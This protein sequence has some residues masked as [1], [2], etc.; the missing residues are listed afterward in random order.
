MSEPWC[1]A[2]DRAIAA[3]ALAVLADPRSPPEHR[4]EARETLLRPRLDLTK[5]STGDLH[6]MRRG[7]A[8]GQ[9]ADPRVFP[10]GPLCCSC[11]APATVVAPAQPIAAVVA[12]RAAQRASEPA[13]E[14]ASEPAAELAYEVASEP[15][16][17]AAGPIAELAKLGGTVKRATVK[18]VVPRRRPM[19]SG[20][21]LDLPDKEPR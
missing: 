15:A 10:P 6:A 3:F 4:A 5:V 19:R 20:E 17:L 7:F 11:G 21:F 18:R 12:P 14:L 2:V 8:I 16:E 13:A 9:G 1:Y